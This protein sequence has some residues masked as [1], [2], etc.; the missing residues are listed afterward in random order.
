MYNLVQVVEEHIFSRKCVDWSSTRQSCR[1]SWTWL[2]SN[3]KPAFWKI[4]MRWRQEPFLPGMLNMIWQDRRFL[5]YKKNQK[6]LTKLPRFGKIEQ[7]HRMYRKKTRP[8][9]QNL[10]RSYSKMLPQRL[11]VSVVHYDS[12]QF[13]KNVLQ[14]LPEFSWN[15]R[16]FFPSE[17]SMTNEL[18]NT[19]AFCTETNQASGSLANA[20]DLHWRPL[21]MLGRNRILLLSISLVY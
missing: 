18:N 13:R 7:N 17:F 19:V 16:L 21:S 15:G 9:R 3:N 14:H 20:L 4:K 5:L 2:A 1:I 6:K 11:T 8:L 10:E 12:G